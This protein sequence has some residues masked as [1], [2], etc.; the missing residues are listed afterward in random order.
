MEADWWGNATA[1][2]SHLAFVGHFSPPH[3]DNTGGSLHRLTVMPGLN[4]DLAKPPAESDNPVLKIW[5]RWPSSAANALAFLRWEAETQ[6]SNASQAVR[7]Q[8]LFTTL[9]GPVQV[10]KL[11]RHDAFVQHTGSVHMV[12]TAHGHPT[13]VTGYPVLSK[14][15]EDAERSAE[16]TQ[17]MLTGI[18][19]LL[20]ENGEHAR[21]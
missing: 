16:Y 9:E 14:D 3:L 4:T 18:E 12:L 19:S 2:S 10:S 6:H 1:L 8:V 21:L 20:D 5:Y 13:V 7:L 17:A 15:I 11:R